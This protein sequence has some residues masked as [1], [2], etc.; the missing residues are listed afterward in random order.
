MRPH[1]QLLPG[2]FIIL[3]LAESHFFSISNHEGKV[4]KLDGAVTE[5]LTAESLQAISSSPRYHVFR[6]T[7][8]QTHVFRLTHAQAAPAITEHQA[9]HVLG[10]A[11]SKPK[12]VT[13]VKKCQSFACRKTYGPS[14]FTECGEKINTA[15]PDDLQ[16]ALFVS[17]KKGFTCDYLSA[18][19]HRWSSVLSSHREQF[20]MNMGPSLALRVVIAFAGFESSTLTL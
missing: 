1:S 14:F 6:L 2:K 15:S 5:A 3:D 16:D 20:A 13:H 9:Y 4:H 11:L 7:R 8:M 10:G 19:T 12:Y 17:V 18:T